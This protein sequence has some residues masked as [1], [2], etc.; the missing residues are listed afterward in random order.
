MLTP[1]VALYAEQYLGREFTQNELRL[2]PYLCDCMINR[3]RVEAART[4]QEE[5]EILRTL[6]KEAHIVREY[7]SYFYPE[8]E[9]YLFMQECL[10]DT[11]I[12]TKEEIE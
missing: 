8:R 7:P 1:E 10:V 4:T 9:F 5:Q 11:Y 12:K 2:Y 3:R 6:E